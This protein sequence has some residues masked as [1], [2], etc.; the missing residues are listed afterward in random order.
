LTLNN[1]QFHHQTHIS[2]LSSPTSR[3]KIITGKK[4]QHVAIAFNFSKIN[5]KIPNI[6]TKSERFWNCISHSCQHLKRFLEINNAGEKF[7]T[8]AAFTSVK[9][10]CKYFMLKKAARTFPNANIFHSVGCNTRR[11]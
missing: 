7:T 6:Y 5:N 10:Q 9:L 3:N 11:C 4:V 2:K 8:V 1:F